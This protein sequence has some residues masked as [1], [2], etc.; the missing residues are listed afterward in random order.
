MKQ[1]RSVDPEQPVDP[2]LP[3]A[4]ELR[5]KAEE[6]LRESEAR[7]PAAEADVRALLHELQVHQIELE[8]Q[9]EELQRAREI[10][11]EASEKYGDLFDFAPVGYF[12]WD[13][14]GRVLEV[15]LAGAALLGLDRGVVI[16]KRLG[17]FVAI[18]DR[19]AFADFSKRVLHAG[20][21]QTTEVAIL[22]AGQ[23]VPIVLEGVAAHD[24]GKTPLCRVAAIDITERKRAEEALQQE[25]RTLHRLFQASD[26]ERQ[27]IAYEIHDGLAQFLTGAVMHFESA[28]GLRKGDP[29]LAASEH[30]AA[31]SLLR[32]ALA[33]ARR[34]ISQFRP[35]VLDDD[36]VAAAISQLVREHRGTDAPEIEF[37]NDATFC[38]LHPVVENTIYRIVQEALTN[39]CKHGKAKRVHIDLAHQGGD[40]VRIEVRDCGVGFDPTTVHDGCFGLQGIRERARLLGGTV[41]VESGSGQGTRIAVVLPLVSPC[42]APSDKP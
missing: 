24:R 19:A 37:H 36:G 20:A 28:E 6:R 2:G 27:L 32:K 15:N 17:Q 4:A 10:A 23:T 14:V 22:R 9:N 39:A 33:E 7:P 35:M 18:E 40:S 12:L 5:R 16:D 11:E 38:R 26:H 30:L 25:R 21:K 31:M 8:M 41:V 42:M 13:A 29:D 34:L 3:Q 1:R